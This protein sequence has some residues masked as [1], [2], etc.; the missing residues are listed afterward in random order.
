[1]LLYTNWTAEKSLVYSAMETYAYAGLE[2]DAVDPSMASGVTEPIKTVNSKGM[3]VAQIPPIATALPVLEGVSTGS[4]HFL[5]KGP[6]SRSNESRKS[7]ER[8]KRAGVERSR[9]RQDYRSD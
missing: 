6:K 4:C 3:G 2:K 8:V 7:V 1:M 9:R 5:W